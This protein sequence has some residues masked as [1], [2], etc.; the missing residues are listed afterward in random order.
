MKC[1][2][3][4]FSI[5]ALLLGVGSATAGYLNV[6]R[7]GLA[8]QG[9]DPVA[10]FTDGKPVMGD[11]NITTTFD[12][13]FG[14]NWVLGDHEI[15]AGADYSDNKVYNAFFQNVNGNYTFGCINGPAGTYTTAGLTGAVTCS[16]LSGSL[17]EA[18]VLENFT[19]GRY[20]GFQVK[21]SPPSQR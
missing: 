12:G 21:P 19:R 16:G 13:Y 2:I 6:D 14:A 11:A 18:A 1:L 20:S 7:N 8:L 3:L 5:L 15:K 10:Y 17:V 9:Y 4:C